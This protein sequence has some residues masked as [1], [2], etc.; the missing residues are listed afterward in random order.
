[1][2]PVTNVALMRNVVSAAEAAL[3]VEQLRNK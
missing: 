2:G 3:T 1:V